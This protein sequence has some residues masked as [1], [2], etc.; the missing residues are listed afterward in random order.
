MYKDSLVSPSP[1]AVPVPPDI[2]SYGPEVG[3]EDDFHLLGDLKGKRVLELGCGMA[4]RSIAFARQGATAI[5]V[6]FSA[7]MIE[8]AKRLCER[9]GVR[10][11]LRQSDLADLAFLRADS[12]DVVFSAYALPYGRDLERVFRQAHRVLKAGAPLV[13]SLRHPIYDVLDDLDA[14]HPPVVTGSYFDRS[15]AM[16]ARGSEVVEVH[17]HTVADLLMGLVRSGFRIDT[18]IEPEPPRARS[19]PVH[20]PAR[21]FVPRALIVR[22][23]KERL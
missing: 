14:F 17:H 2:V 22:A 12:V 18:V 16:E 13:F 9:E 11:E 8:S 5:G 1:G 15:T 7:E 6:D 23:R 19:N 3:S 10:V 20:H 4:E 21:G